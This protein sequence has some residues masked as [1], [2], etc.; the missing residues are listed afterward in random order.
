MMRK[1]NS[2][3]LIFHSG[4]NLLFFRKLVP[5]TQ[6]KTAVAVYTRNRAKAMHF[7]SGQEASMMVSAL[8]RAFPSYLPELFSVENPAAERNAISA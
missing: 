3:L 1:D 4:S 6:H 2:M 8:S 7:R 5:A